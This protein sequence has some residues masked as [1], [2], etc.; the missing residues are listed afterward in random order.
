MCG[1][2][3]SWFK[4]ELR[5]FL[6][7]FLPAPGKTSEEQQSRDDSQSEND[8]ERLVRMAA[9]EAIGG[10]RSDARAFLH[11]AGAGLEQLFAVAHHGFDVF[12]ELF[13]INARSVSVSRFVSHDNHH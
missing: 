3:E 5:T 2:E 1:R 13:E 6:F 8:A 4:F 12:Q 7:F 10:L 11:F 9:H